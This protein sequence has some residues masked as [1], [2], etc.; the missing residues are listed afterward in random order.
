MNIYF[1][2][3]HYI[4]FPI[5]QLQSMSSFKKLTLG[6]LVVL[7][8]EKRLLLV[9]I[10]RLPQKNS[11]LTEYPM[12]A[13][14]IY[15]GNNMPKLLPI[16]YFNDGYNNKICDIES[17]LFLQN[18][19]KSN[20]LVS[21]FI[22]ETLALATRKKEKRD[23]QI[24]KQLLEC[25]TIIPSIKQDDDTYHKPHI[26]TNGKLLIVEKFFTTQ[27]QEEFYDYISLGLTEREALV[28]LRRKYPKIFGKIL[29]EFQDKDIYTRI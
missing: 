24:A 6:D 2:S 14:I 8:I 25:S 17:L 10:N 18:T 27:M 23:I 4:N 22:T 3:Y 5:K 28:K 15:K 21:D 26:P 11:K 19:F 29:L 13:Q 1:I 9:I 20:K 16:I 7:K 12:I